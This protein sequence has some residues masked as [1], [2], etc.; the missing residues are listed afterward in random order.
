MGIILAVRAPSM[1][2]IHNIT[3]FSPIKLLFGMDDPMPISL[4]DLLPEASASTFSGARILLAALH[5]R[6]PTD[7]LTA[8]DC[9]FTTQCPPFLAST[10]DALDR[11]L[12]LDMLV[13]SILTLESHVTRM[14]QERQRLYAAAYNNTSE[15][16]KEHRLRF[17]ELQRQ[18]NPQHRYQFSPDDYALVSGTKAAGLAPSLHGPFQ[19]VRITNG[20]NA[21]IQ[22]DDAGTHR[23]Q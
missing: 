1:R 10:L 11:R 12:K 22:T 3:G 13:H 17:V 2:R 8:S 23:A 15:R 5:H 18:R 21:I 9:T 4:G 7:V 19:L 20:G 14:A 6:L 16:Q